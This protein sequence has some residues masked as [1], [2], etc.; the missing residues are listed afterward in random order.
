M[1]K[2]AQQEMVGFVLIV[3]VVVIALLVFMIFKISQPAKVHE[4]VSVDNVLQGIMQTSSFCK[5]SQKSGY[6]RIE[7]MFEDCYDNKRC[8]N[9]DK[10]VCEELNNTLKEILNKI[11][12][13]DNRISAYEL[14]SV[15]S[16]EDDLQKQ[17]TIIDGNCSSSI[18]GSNP[19]VVSLG[20]DGDIIID[21]KLCMSN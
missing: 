19:Y 4:S 21:L 20:N 12:M 13:T 3:I 18:Y 2:K 7:D 8:I 15:Y 10:M 16:Y 1:Y 14:N 6:Q 9:T 11:L 17:L 5:V